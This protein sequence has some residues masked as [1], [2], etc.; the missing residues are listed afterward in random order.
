MINGSEK[1]YITRIMKKIVEFIAFLLAVLFLQSCE[2][3]L[4]EVQR[5]YKT[6]FVPTG[7]ADS[8]NLKYTDSGRVK[9]IL[10]SLKMID[11][12]TA[13]NPF[14]EFPKAVLVTLIDANGNK[15]IVVADKAI[16]Y[17]KT[18][19]IDLIGNVKI[20]TYDGKV[21]ATNQLYFDQKNEWFFTEEAFTFKDADGSFLQG[22]GIDFSKD[23]KIFNMQNNNGEVNNM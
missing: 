19:V 5:I 13:K 14:V 8:I 15:T 16:S 9:S 18:E 21:L 12:S 3:N 20:K 10:Q 22:I 4:K 11:Y 7:E 17:K 6:S 2:S 1:H 23:F